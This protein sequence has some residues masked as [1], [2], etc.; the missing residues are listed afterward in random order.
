MNALI[1]GITGQDGSYLAEFLLK[2]G[3]KVYGVARRNST[4]NHQRIEY[5]FLNENFSLLEGDVTDMVS[6]MTIF[7]SILDLDEVYNLAAQSHV[8]TSFN[9]PSYTFSVTAGG[10]INI[11]ETMRLLKIK[12]R[13]YQA[14]SSEMFGRSYS[15]WQGAKCQYEDT[16]MM[17]QSPYAIA[18]LAAHNAVGMYRAAYDM[19][20][21]SGILFNH[22]SERRGHNFVT[23]KVIRHAVNLMV[24]GKE[25]PKLRLG[26]M[27]AIRDWGHAE[28]Y[29]R[30]M[31]MMVQQDKPI[32]FV[33][34][35]GHSHTVYELVEES[36][37]LAGISQ[38]EAHQ[39]VEYNCSE[40]M[41]PSEV[42]YLRARAV[43]ANIQLGWKPQINFRQLVK[44]MFNY[45]AQQRLGPVVCSV[46][47]GSVTQGQ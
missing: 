29:V 33:I 38:D 41:R 37:K 40:F 4:S 17:P 44:R 22:E 39:Y 9:Q 43:K 6:L 26:N 12:A 5:L 15:L 2:Q 25:I 14:S 34:G 18:K 31:W 20:A 35:T 21:V 3:Y 30:A 7:S 28:D 1:F 10:C 42:P 13:F 23:Q 47:E 46:Q 11:L 19:F 36:F 8:G 27:M 32:D 45:E 16:P 24:D